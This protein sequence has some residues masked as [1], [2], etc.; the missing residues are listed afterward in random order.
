MSETPALQQKAH[1]LNVSFFMIRAAIYFAFWSLLALLLNW[2][3]REQDRTGA[4]R[5]GKRLQMISGPGLAFLIISIT[6]ASIDWVMSLE[7]KWSSTI[8]GFIFVAAWSL[9]AL[10]FSIV[11]LSWLSKRAPMD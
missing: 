1:Y 10:A 11:A 3:S 2:L 7:P 5:I 9:S 6:F 4:K 8:F